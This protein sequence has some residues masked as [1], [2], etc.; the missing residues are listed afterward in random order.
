VSKSRERKRSRRVQG[1]GRRE[2]GVVREDL[3][4]LRR[5]RKE[6]EVSSPREGESSKRRWTYVW[7]E[8]AEEVS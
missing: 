6:Q 5:G 2:S 3:I 4:D 1:V 8:F 7:R